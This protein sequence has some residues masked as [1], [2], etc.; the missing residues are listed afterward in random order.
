ML[1]DKLKNIISA[2][3]DSFPNIGARERQ[4]MRNQLNGV[5]TPDGKA[6]LNDIRMQMFFEG[7]QRK[8]VLARA[9]FTELQKRVDRLQELVTAALDPGRL[10]ETKAT[11]DEIDLLC[12]EVKAMM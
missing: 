5:E 12:E 8:A 2:Y 3:N 9:Q 7:T 6:L 11:F 4:I 10:T 1:N